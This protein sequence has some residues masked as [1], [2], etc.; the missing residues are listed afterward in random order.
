[1]FLLH[2]YRNV[3]R[4][5]NSNIWGLS[6]K[7]IAL[8]C[9]TQNPTLNLP[10]SVNKCKTD[11][12]TYLLMRPC[13]F[14]FLICKFELLCQTVITRDKNR[15]SSPIST[16]LYSVSYRTNIPSMTGILKSGPFLQSLALT[17]IKD[18]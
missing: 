4:R 3:L 14:N 11:I 10:Y 2:C 9:P 1:M 17:L 18:T 6:I 12:K 7:V 13:H 5:Q 16:S 15:S 8:S